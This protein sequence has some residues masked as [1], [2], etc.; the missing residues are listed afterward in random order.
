[1]YVRCI[2]L[3]TVLL[4]AGLSNN[5]LDENRYTLDSKH[6]NIPSPSHNQNKLF[7]WIWVLG[8]MKPVFKFILKYLCRWCEYWIDLKAG[9]F[10]KLYQQ[11]HLIILI[12]VI[13]STIMHCKLFFKTLSILTS[14]KYVSVNFNLET[15]KQLSKP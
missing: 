1:M 4:W 3:L 9:Y 6:W 5:S 7:Q 11:L 13:N 15:I 8:D 14:S 2:N 12:K 10:A